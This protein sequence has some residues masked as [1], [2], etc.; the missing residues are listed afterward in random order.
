MN[1]ELS[2]FIIINIIYR[3]DIVGIYCRLTLQSII[4]L[5]SLLLQCN[6]CRRNKVVADC[7]DDDVDDEISKR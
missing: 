3:S 1:I 7:N 6:T 2:Y 4:K 5:N